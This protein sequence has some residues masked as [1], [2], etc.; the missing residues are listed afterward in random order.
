MVAQ[1]FRPDKRVILIGPAEAAEQISP[2]GVDETKGKNPQT[3]YEVDV[4]GSNEIANCSDDGAA[5]EC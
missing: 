4:D 3:R 2:H 1:C 5:P